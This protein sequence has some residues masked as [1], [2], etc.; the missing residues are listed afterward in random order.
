VLYD[1]S[2]SREALE[3]YAVSRGVA[4]PEDYPNK[5][6]LRWHFFFFWLCVVIERDCS[7]AHT[8]PVAQGSYSPFQHEHVDVQA[9]SP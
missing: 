4:S 9:L 7:N 3:A 6:E 8:H 1:D 2:A 5:K